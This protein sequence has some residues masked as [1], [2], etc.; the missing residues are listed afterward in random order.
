MKRLAA[1]AS[2]LAV[3]WVIALTSICSAQGFFSIQG[4]VTDAAGAAIPDAQV[5][6]TNLATNKASHTTTGATGRFIFSAVTLEPQLV[7]IEKTGFQSLVQRVTP[8]T[9]PTVTGLS[10]EFLRLTK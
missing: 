7:T 2:V 10:P 5:T 3:S 8:G 6:L 1:L 9:Q 4:K